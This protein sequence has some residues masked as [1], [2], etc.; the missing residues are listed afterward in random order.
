VTDESKAPGRFAI[1]SV[2][3][4]VAAAMIAG[5]ILV[6]FG[7]NQWLGEDVRVPAGIVL[8]LIGIADMVWLVPMLARRWRSQ[9]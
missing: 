4:L 8:I 2:L 7:D 5:G 9:P 1:L 3:R 6:A